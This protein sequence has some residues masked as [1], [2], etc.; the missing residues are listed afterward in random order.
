MGLV[1]GG[2]EDDAVVGGEK[3][4]VRAKVMA[5]AKAKGG[6]VEV[7]SVVSYGVLMQRIS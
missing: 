6:V 7:E 4:V 3:K 5:L 2:A 1:V